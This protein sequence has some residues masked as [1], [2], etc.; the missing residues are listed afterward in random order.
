M[1]DF[2]Y[3]LA[4]LCGKNYNGFHTQKGAFKKHLFAYNVEK[5]AKN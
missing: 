4:I 2:D 3:G 5:V 1:V